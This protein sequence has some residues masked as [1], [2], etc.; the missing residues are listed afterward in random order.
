MQ[1][2]DWDAE[3][4]KQAVLDERGNERPQLAYYNQE[5]QMSF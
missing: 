5:W 2:P 1:D 4:D 3:S